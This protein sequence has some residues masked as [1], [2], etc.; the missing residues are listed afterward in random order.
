[1]RGVPFHRPHALPTFDPWPALT[2]RAGV[3]SDTKQ[4][5]ARVVIEYDLLPGD[6]IVVRDREE[7]RWITCG[8]L[9]A[10]PGSATVKV[11]LFEAPSM[12]AHVAPRLASDPSRA[13]APSIAPKQGASGFYPPPRIAREPWSH[14]AAAPRK[15]IGVFY[16]RTQL[17]TFGV[18]TRGVMR[19]SPRGRKRIA[20]WNAAGLCPSA[21]AAEAPASLTLSSSCEGCRGD[22]SQ[23]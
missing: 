1:M 9:L 20:L 4:M 10:L 23:V 15:G 5:N 7:Q 14:A 6:R 21:N 19:V 13:A 12:P 17:T 3:G 22:F 11:E 16:L 8:T 2:P 18:L